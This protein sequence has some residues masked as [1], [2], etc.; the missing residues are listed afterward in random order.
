MSDRAFAFLTPANAL[1]KLAFSEVHD[2]L[3]AG[4][5]N[6][7]TDGAQAACRRRMRV[8]PE[9]RR[10]DEIV[11]LRREMERPKYDTDGEASETL[12]EPDSDTNEQLG[13][14]LG[15]VWDGS[16]LLDLQSPPAMPERGWTAGKGPLENM[17]I[18]LLLCTRAFA[19]THDIKLRN[20]HARFNFFLENKG[21]FIMGCSRSPTAQLTVNGDGAT[22]G[23][24]HLNQ[25]IMKIQLDKLEYNFQWT[26]NATTEDFK[27]ARRRYVVRALRGGQQAAN[28]DV[29]MPT[30]L[31]NRR[32]MGKWTLGDALGAGGNGR[33]F[34]ASDRSGNV[35]AI[36]VVERTSRNCDTVDEEINILQKATDLANSSVDGERILRMEQVIYSNGEEFSS[37]TAFDN[38]AIVLKPMTPQTFGDLLGTRSKGVQGHD[39]GGG[40][41]L[42]LRTAWC[43]SNARQTLGAP[44]PEAGQHRATRLRS[45]LLDVGTSRHIPADGS[46]L[47][48]PGTVGTIGYLAPELELEAYDLSIDIWPMGV[49]L[50]ELTY[51]C[52]PWKLSINPWRDGKDN[53][54]LR[55]SFRKSYQNA[56]AKMARD[57][58]SALASPTRGYIHLGRLFIDMVR[59]QWAPNNHAQRPDIDQVLQHPAWGPLLPESPQPKKRRL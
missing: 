56:I 25:H 33:V 53:E 44:R 28:I 21:L 39:N 58:K 1:A 57:Y 6:S 22:R 9:Q 17:P 50:Y 5:Q 30:P 46:L 34:F 55:D 23:P 48:T 12:T 8:E 16:Y 11:R 7:Q 15:M 54:A 13:R 36:K 20:P 49:I 47:P 32:T 38:V 10:D 14:E 51:N 26:E 18:D 43:Q 45:V 52:H 29:E 4:G 41:C 40:D 31:P 37:K 19:K 59:Y 35:A 27:L 42:P 24:Y 3:T 2:A